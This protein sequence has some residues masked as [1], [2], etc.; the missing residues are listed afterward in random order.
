ML[1]DY[2][3]REIRHELAIQDSRF[4]EQ[5]HDPFKWLS[6]LTEELGEAAQ[7]AND[8]FD[9]QNK[10]WKPSEVERYR[11]ELIQV[12]AVAKAM[13]ESLDRGKWNV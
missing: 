11:E 2:L 10:C 6:I 3:E 4:S 9:W 1:I 12:A 5:N 7:A 13:L 8:A